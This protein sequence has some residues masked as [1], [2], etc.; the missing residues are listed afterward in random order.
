MDRVTVT[1]Y[2]DVLESV[3]DFNR[4]LEQVEQMKDKLRFFRAWYYIPEQDAVGPSKFIGY[5]G[6]TAE[7]YMRSHTELD[8]RVTEPVLSQWFNRLERDTLEADF[9][10]KKVMQLLGRYGKSVNSIA[11]FNVPRGWR[12]NTQKHT[13]QP[14]PVQAENTMVVPHPIVDVFWRAFLSLYPED[15]KALAERIINHNR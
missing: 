5:K 1:N 12:M 7:E 11:R 2:E 13:I 8:G 15:Q 10:R 9:V 6:M 4:D 14:T 3:R